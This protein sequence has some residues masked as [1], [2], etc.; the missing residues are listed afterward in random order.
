MEVAMFLAE[1]MMFFGN[2]ELDSEEGRAYLDFAYSDTISSSFNSGNSPETVANKIFLMEYGV[3]IYE[4][5]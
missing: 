1:I 3:S 5:N 4:E 2:T